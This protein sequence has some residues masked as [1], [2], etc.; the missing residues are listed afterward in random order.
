MIGGMGVDEY[1]RTRT[2]AEAKEQGLLAPEGD[3]L[4]MRPSVTHG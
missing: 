1:W 3:V 2:I 4:R